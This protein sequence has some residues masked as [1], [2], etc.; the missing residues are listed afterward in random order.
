MEEGAC[1]C[2]LRGVRL[3]LTVLPWKGHSR[4]LTCSGSGEQKEKQLSPQEHGRR[5]EDRK[6]TIRFNGWGC[7]ER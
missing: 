7:Q 4:K 3:G 5:S 6:S 2:V 1:A